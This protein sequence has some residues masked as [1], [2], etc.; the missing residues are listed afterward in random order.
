[1]RFDLPVNS[2]SSVGVAA[3]L[4]T[5]SVGSFCS[6]RDDRNGDRRRVVGA[7]DCDP[8]AI[9][10]DRPWGHDGAERSDLT[11]WPNRTHRLHRPNWTH[12]SYTVHD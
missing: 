1:M 12:R 10:P 5:G 7:T 3:Q 11:F 8:G 4:P 9:W 2:E 6:G